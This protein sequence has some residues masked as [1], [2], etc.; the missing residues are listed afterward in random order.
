MVR[1]LEFQELGPLLA[2]SLLEFIFQIEIFEWFPVSKESTVKSRND[3][4]KIHLFP[5]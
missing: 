1:F 3:E 2:E 4:P 5:V